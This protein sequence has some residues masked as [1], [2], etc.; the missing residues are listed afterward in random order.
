M[1]HSPSD[2]LVRGQPSGWPDVQLPNIPRRRVLLTDYGA[3][4]DGIAMNTAAF[5]AAIDACA[6]AGGGQVVIPPGIWLTGPI[7][8]R[9]RIELHAQKGAL[10]RF[11]ADFDDYELIPSTF[12]GLATVRCRS[13]LDGEGL[14]DVAITGEGVFDG[15]GDVWRPAKKRKLTEQQWQEKVA[16]GGVTDASG[17]VWWP[18]AAAL[19]G[20]AKV[21][22][23]IRA[24]RTEPEAFREARDYLRPNLLSLRNCKR[25]LLEGPTFQNSAAWCLHPW[26]SEHVT[27]RRVTVRNPWYSQNGDGLDLDSCRFALVEQCSFDVGDDAICLKSGKDEAGRKLGKPCEYV[28]VRDCTVYHG[29]GGIVVGSEMSG[30]VRRVRVSD[31]LFVGTDIGIRFK[32]ARGRGGVVEDI[33]IERIRMLDLVYDAISFNLFYE[34][35]EGSG[36]VSKEVRPVDEGTPIFRDIR[37]ADI[38]CTGANA[39]L[40]VNGLPEAPLEGLTVTNLSFASRIGVRCTNAVRVNL[41]DLRLLTEEGPLV[42]FDDCQDAAAAGIFNRRTQQLEEPHVVG[43]EG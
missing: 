30:G 23:L 21:E 1:T 13:P 35:V 28:M 27:V 3:V 31:C 26:A 42:V 8:L 36:T 14:E 4:G 25:I 29:H 11:S 22:E 7:V 24:G 33:G 16:S 9:S 15:N 2:R 10:V 37:I 32:S 17:Q 39:A 20:G 6:Q 5:A 34:G 38:A 18:S 41:E 40:L 12:E 43:A 19:R